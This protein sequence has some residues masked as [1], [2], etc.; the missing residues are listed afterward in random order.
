MTR[1]KLLSFESSS[2]YVAK[3]REKLKGSSKGIKS[4]EE[5][6]K[7][8]NS[9]FKEGESREGQRKLKT[10]RYDVKILQ[11]AKLWSGIRI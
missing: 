7:L 5:T 3:K 1:P 8:T 10:K 6:K 4:F 11:N 9:K 2:A